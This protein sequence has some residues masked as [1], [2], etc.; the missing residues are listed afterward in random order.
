MHFLQHGDDAMWV[1]KEKRAIFAA[2][3]IKL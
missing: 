1:A 2:M 3:G